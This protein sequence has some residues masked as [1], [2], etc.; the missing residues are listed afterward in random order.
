MKKELLYMLAVG[1]MIGLATYYYNKGQ[2]RQVALRYTPGTYTATAEGYHGPITLDVTFT[3]DHLTDIAIVSEKETEGVGEDAL[4]IYTKRIVEAQ[5]FGVDV[6]TGATVTCKAVREAVSQAVQQAQVSDYAAFCRNRAPRKAPVQI[7]DT[8]DVVIVG[9]GGAGM[10]A[11]A[12]VAQEGLSVL[13]IEKNASLGGN[14][15]VSGGAYQSVVPYLVW[16][17]KQPDATEGIGYDGLPH[18]KMLSAKGCL[19]TL[20]TL[21][22]WS[23]QPFDA[24]WYRHHKF[25]AGNEVELSRHGVHAEYLPVLKALKQEIRAYMQWA[26]RR[27]AQGV[28]EEQLTLFSTANLHIFQTYYGGLRPSLDGKE[29]C[30]GDVRL[31]T[32]FVEEGIQ[33]RPW[34][35]NMGVDFLE[36]QGI[37]V[38]ALWYRTNSMS[39]THVTLKGKSLTVKGNKGPYVM[40]P[41][42]VMMSANKHNQ[43]MYLTSARDLIVE[44]G[45]VVG[46]KAEG[47][48]GAHITAYARKGVILCTGGYAAN[49]KK[50]IET[51][52]YWSSQSLVATTKT[53]NRTTMQGDGIWMAQAAG[54]DVTGMGWTQLLPLAFARTGSIAFGSVDN[55]I[56]VSPQ[57]GE[58][59]IDELSERDVL[60]LGAF[61]HGIEMLGARGV[62]FYITGEQNYNPLAGPKISDSEECQYTTT[63]DQLPALFKQLS[64]SPTLADKVVQTIRQFDQAILEGRQPQGATRAYVDN[65]IGKVEKRPDG[66]YDPATY[67]LEHTRIV[68]RLLAPATHHTMG[69]LLVDTQRRVLDTHGRPIPGLYAAGEVTGGIHGG[70]RLGGN[71]LTDVLVS[72]RIA[73]RSVAASAAQS[74]GNT[75]RRN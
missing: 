61:E 57:T 66:S 31:V 68:F 58:R 33:L 43:V 37:I 67:D 72:G 40:A 42:S 19:A 12:Q 6:V 52:R 23:E 64:L 18:T 48:D 2:Q 69:G 24:A 74:S 59:Y 4:P 50:V 35:M 55:A 22:D 47:D 36:K 30:Y 16:D 63:V 62:H 21:L 70:N 44:G 25:V 54:A 38:G 1:L 71:A 9:G 45:R 3:P 15:L 7:T 53:T 10:A 46:I 73:G 39:A 11:A 65:L 56:F 17:P 34:L 32:Q 13:V 49:V 51:N 5:G 75:V 60:S 28:K 26:Q 14:T 8:W 20:Q 29:W 27:M 41:Y